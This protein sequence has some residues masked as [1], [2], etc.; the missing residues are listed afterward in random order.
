MNCYNNK[1][2][3]NGKWFYKRWM[4][5]VNRFYSCCL[6]EKWRC[7]SHWKYNWYLLFVESYEDKKKPC[8]TLMSQFLLI[9]TTIGQFLFL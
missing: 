9:Q 2:N 3:V 7:L 8:L 6:M 5:R 1:S 4:A